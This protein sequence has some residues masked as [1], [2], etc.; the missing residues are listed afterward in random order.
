MKLNLG[1]GT[2]IKHGWVN[3]DRFP[4][5]GVNHVQ[6]ITDPL[7]FDDEAVEEV[8]A[9]HVLEHLAEWENVVLEIHRVLKV[10]GKL[11]IRVPYGLCLQTYHKR[12]FD[13]LTLDGFIQQSQFF[14]SPSIEGFPVFK[15]LEKS[16]DRDYPF[17]WHVKRYL[18]LMLP[19]GPKAIIT[20]V[21][22]K[23]I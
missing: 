7:P 9:S 20:W 12:F 4:G 2:D 23:V 17:A 13:E 19:L 18:G 3:I 15:C 6:D 8:L 22:E 11:T 21:L 1:C 10:G 16:V 14:K 5:P